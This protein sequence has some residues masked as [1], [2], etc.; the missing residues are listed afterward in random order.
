MPKQDKLSTS[1]LTCHARIYAATSQ[2][3]EMPKTPNM[4]SQDRAEVQTE[5]SKAMTMKT[6]GDSDMCSPS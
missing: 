3:L 1:N 4:M 5:V 6:K 2:G